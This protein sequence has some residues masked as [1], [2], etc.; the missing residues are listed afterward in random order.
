MQQPVDIEYVVQEY[1]KQFFDEPVS[2]GIGSSDPQVV[3]FTTGGSEVTLVSARPR[4]VFDCYG[5][6]EGQAINLANKVWA[7]VKNL[8]CR[9]VGGV[10]FYDVEAT[11]PMNLP[12]P[13]R[14]DVYRRQFNAII[15]TRHER[16]S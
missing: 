5:A 14:P 6:T 9:V 3:L 1:L 16:V 12:H 2:T 15:H 4:V 11:L 10:Q 7:R 8:E 13:D